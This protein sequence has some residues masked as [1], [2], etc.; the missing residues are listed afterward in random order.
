MSAARPTWQERAD[1]MRAD[2]TAL[3]A[4]VAATLSF[5]PA[6]WLAEARRAGVG[7]ML[8]PRGGLLFHVAEAEHDAWSA[9]LVWLNLTGGAD[10]AVIA[11]LEREAETQA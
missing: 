10:D 7:V 2:S 11:L 5:D 9:L 4:A 1:A 6:Y 3:G 8:S